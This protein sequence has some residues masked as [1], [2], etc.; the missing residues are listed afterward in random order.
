MSLR[1]Y[2]HLDHSARIVK[3]IETESKMVVS[4]DREERKLL[5]NRHRVSVWEDEKDLEMDEVGV[6]QQCEYT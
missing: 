3:F 6:S 5:F 1:R 4:N 2:K